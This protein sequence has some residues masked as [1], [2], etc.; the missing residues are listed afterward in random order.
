MRDENSVKKVDILIVDDNPNNLLAMESV[1]ESPDINIIT[2]TSGQEALWFLF[3]YE[4]ALI[5][6]D[7]QMPE[8]DG[9]ETAELMR[10]TEKTKYVPII[11]ATAINKEREHISKGYE[12]GAVDYLF[13]PIDPEILKNKV[14]VFLE[15]FR[16]KQKI[17]DQAKEIKENMEKF[18]CITSSAQDAIVLVDDDGSISYWNEAAVRIFDYKEDEIIGRNFRILI[19]KRYHEKLNEKFELVKNSDDSDTRGKVFEFFA[20]KRNGEEISI[21]VS[22]ASL[23]IHKKWCSL[24]IIRDISERKAFE[25]ELDLLAHFDILTKIPNRKLFFDRLSHNLSMANRYNYMFALLYIDIDRFKQINDTLGHNVGDSLLKEVAIRLQKCIRESDTV[26]RIGGDEFN[27]ILTKIESKKDACIIAE[28][29]IKAFKIHFILSEKEHSIDISIGI[30][31]YPDNGDNLETLLTK[32]DKAMYDAKKIG[33]SNYIVY[34][35]DM[36]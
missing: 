16:N 20:V 30:S 2:A 8:M 34:D 26:A 14:K 27:I 25:K 31:F 11:F 17:E 22:L 1:L 18:R 15:L 32:A 24:G 10:K 4:F 23:T 3:K 12:V 21:E 36:N 5:I 19:P 9:F 33:G 29:I 7:V 13:K 28:R 6:L 35:A